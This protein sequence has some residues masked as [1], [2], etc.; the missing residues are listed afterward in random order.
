MGL[1]VAQVLIFCTDDIN[2]W[3][4]KPQRE[5]E[6]TYFFLDLNITAFAQKEL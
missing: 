3:E 6:N 2:Q 5:A 4:K 1:K